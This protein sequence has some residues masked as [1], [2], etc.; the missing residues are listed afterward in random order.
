MNK[1]VFF[2]GRL[3]NAADGI[4]PGTASAALYGRGVFTTLLILDRTPRH[5]YLHWER[6]ARDS[7]AIGL[8]ISSISESELLDGLQ[9]LADSCGLTAGKAR[10]TLLDMS[11]PELWPSEIETRTV[12]L[13]QLA[14]VPEAP[15]GIA[16]TISPFVVSSSS[17]LK[18]I[19]SCNYLEHQMCFNEARA[20]GFDEAIRFDERGRVSSGCRSNVFWV[21]AASG[22][23]CTPSSDTGCIIGT[24]RQLIL[25]YGAAVE[26]DVTLTEL[27]NDA[28]AVFFTS[29]VRGAVIVTRIDGRLFGGNV[30]DSIARLLNS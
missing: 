25:D 8:D 9:Q 7:H 13:I 10:I 1:K 12:C 26:A 6:L 28:E 21:S 16:A 4:L 2:D 19:K 30:P 15:T 24:T 5:W 11:P 22:K 29:A 27:L 23:I 14:E 18:G 3:C 20:R 17:P